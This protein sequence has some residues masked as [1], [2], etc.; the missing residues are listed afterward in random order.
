MNI[1]PYTDLTYFSVFGHLWFFSCL[2]KSQNS[3]CYACHCTI[4]RY[5]RCF[6]SQVLCGISIMAPDY[7]L[8]SIGPTCQHGEENHTWLWQCVARNAFDPP[9]YQAPL[10]HNNTIFKFYIAFSIIIA[11]CDMP[12]CILSTIHLFFVA[13]CL[14]I[15][16]SGHRS[17]TSRLVLNVHRSV[18][19]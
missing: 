12:R 13:W 1:S 5:R 6:P 10:I 8:P 3:K 2:S 11:S 17:F 9:Q 18:T 14:N 4:S 7:I 16:L 19:N 15:C